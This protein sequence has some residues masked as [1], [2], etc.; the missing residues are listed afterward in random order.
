MSEKI[1]YEPHP[2]S[3][4]RV[5]ELRSQGFII[6]D[7]IYDPDRWKKKPANVYR[8]MADNLSDKPFV[9]ELPMK[10]GPGRPRK[11]PA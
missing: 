4:E 1:I 6:L 8:E 5:A 10:R 3:P 2:V 11:E 7:A 9:Q